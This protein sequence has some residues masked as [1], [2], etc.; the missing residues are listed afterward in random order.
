MLPKRK[1]CFIAPCNGKI[2]KIERNATTEKFAESEC[3]KIVMNINYFSDFYLYAPCNGKVARVTDD[4]LILNS[5]KKK[6]YM[7]LTNVDSFNLPM[8]LFNWLYKMLFNMTKSFS[9]LDFTLRKD[10]KFFISDDIIITNYFY[11]TLEIYVE[12]DTQLYDLVENQTLI[13]RDSVL[14][15]IDKSENDD[16]E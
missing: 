14:F 13:A 11:N 9:K 15:L 2:I 1:N 12:R 6:I 10:D 8:P 4:G 5:G 7:R 16:V 3:I